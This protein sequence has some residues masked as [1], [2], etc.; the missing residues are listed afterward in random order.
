MWY[1]FAL[2]V[3]LFLYTLLCFGVAVIEWTKDRIKLQK[4]QRIHQN[5]IC[6][7]CGSRIDAGPI[8]ESHD[9]DEDDPEDT[10]LEE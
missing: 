7:T 3:F 6:P 10:P 5:A 1:N 4:L 9:P 2:M 8:S